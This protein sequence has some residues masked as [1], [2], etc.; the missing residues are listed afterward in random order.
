MRSLIHTLIPLPQHGLSLTRGRD[1]QLR[2]HLH[3][4][5][6]NRGGGG[7]G[8]G[9][10]SSQPDT[11]THSGEI[12]VRMGHSTQQSMDLYRE[13][14]A[15]LCDEREAGDRS[16]FFYHCG[17][18]NAHLRHMLQGAQWCGDLKR[19]ALARNEVD[20]SGVEALCGDYADDVL[21]GLQLLDLS[22]NSIGH[23][24][25]RALARELITGD[26]G[27]G[28]ASS[29]KEFRIHT[30]SEAA[31]AAEVHMEDSCSLWSQVLRGN[32]TLEVMDLSNM[33]NLPRDYCV[34]RARNE[35]WYDLGLT[36]TMVGLHRCENLAAGLEVNRSV[37]ALDLSWF[38]ITPPGF[39]TLCSAVSLAST[40]EKLRIG[41][42]FIDDKGCAHFASLLRSEKCSVTGVELVCNSIGNVGAGHIADALRCNR[43]LTRL[44]MSHNFIESAGA[45]AILAS[46]RDNDTLAYLDLS[47]NAHLWRGCSRSM[48]SQIA[49]ALAR[50]TSLKVLKLMATGTTDRECLMLARVLESSRSIVEVDL[51]RNDISEVGLRILLN[52]V[53]NNDTIRRISMYHNPVDVTP[54]VIDSIE[55]TAIEL[56]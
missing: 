14:D 56:L 20:D 50:N 51:S 10:S 15:Q 41:W 27:S 54:A 55:N 40:V 32:D 23:G 34:S 4:S 25:R 44:D 38:Y 37:K 7:G 5:S 36:R 33:W 26:G 3:G 13:I 16:L 48:E 31:A 12:H 18:R 39:E 11:E 6:G 52:A 42:N 35:R 53:R 19:L 22:Y 1:L 49:D 46:L 43:S 24:G 30:S 2:R 21:R 29:M 45:S 9:G 17:V 28:R 8:R 47:D